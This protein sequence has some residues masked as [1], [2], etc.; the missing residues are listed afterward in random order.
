MTTGAPTPPARVRFD[1]FRWIVEH[2]ATVDSV[3][4]SGAAVLTVLIGLAS[5]TWTGSWLISALMLAAGAI[6]RVRPG[7]SALII[8]SLAV[9]HLILGVLGIGFET[10]WVFGDIMI[11]Y[12]LFCATAHGTVRTGRLALS[13]AILG[14]FLQAAATGLT[15]V[16]RGFDAWLLLFGVLSFGGCILVLGVWAMGRYQHARVDQ[17]RLARERAVQAERDREQRAALAVA[18]ERARIAREMHDVVAHSLS[19][20]I[21]QAD[22]GRFVATQDPAQA[23]RVLET[24]GTTGR[25]ALADMRSLLGVLRH[26]EESSFGPQPDLGALPDLLDRVRATG[27]GVHD[28]ITGPLGDL[29]PSLGLSMFRL[30]Q[31][32]LTNVL[33]HAGPGASASVRVRRS[34]TELAIDVLDDGRGHDP[35][36]DGQGQGLTGMRERVALHGG[37]LAAGPL[38]G[39]GFRVSARIPLAGT[40]SRPP[41]IDPATPRTLAPQPS[42]RTTP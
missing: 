28:E 15:D 29:P 22:G 14:A 20:I 13:A 18:D 2:P 11:F 31:E 17:L 30:V 1:P 33:K 21:A 19:V 38:P 3:I 23:V 36:S 24:I 10:T 41:V 26:D 39:G 16:S 42:R 32:A 4:F 9:L 34:P 7:I 6:G 37:T 8:G 27:L 40:P 25:A 35:A 5:G 12:A